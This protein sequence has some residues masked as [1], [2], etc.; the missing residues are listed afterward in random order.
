V[1]FMAFAAAGCTDGVGALRSLGARAG[2]ALARQ[3]DVMAVSLLGSVARGDASLDSDVDLLVITANETRRSWLLRRLPPTMRIERLSLQCL[4]TK[5]WEAEAERGSL[6]LHHVRLE[7][8][9]LYDPQG[10]LEAGLALVSGRPPDTAGE[11]R[12]QHRRL[13]LYRDLSRLNGQHLFALAHLY[14][15]GKATAIA[16]CIEFGEP[17]FVKEQ[18][19]RC[20]AARRPNVAEAANVISRLRPF[21]DLTRGRERALPFAA[22]AADDEVRRAVA[23]IEKLARE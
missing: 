11:I 5:R 6:F 1:E 21:Y 3:P 10:V 2:A 19:L 16:R 18:A 15:I 12:R 4:S 23:A 8:Q 13:N 9:T 7:G 20:L 22:S 14:A 17:I